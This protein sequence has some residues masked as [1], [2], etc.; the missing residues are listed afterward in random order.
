MMMEAW[1]LSKCQ[2]HG[3][4]LYVYSMTVHLTLRTNY[5]EGLLLPS[6]TYVKIKAQTGYTLVYGY[7]GCKWQGLDLNL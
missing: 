5:A 4:S 3:H 7:S 6:F 1:D 2:V